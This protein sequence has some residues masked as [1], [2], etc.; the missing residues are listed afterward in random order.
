MLQ[1]DQNQPVSSENYCCANDCQSAASSGNPLSPYR[2][3]EPR[4]LLPSRNISGSDL[5][6]LTICELMPSATLWILFGQLP[7]PRSGTYLTDEFET[8]DGVGVTDAEP[9]LRPGSPG[10]TRQ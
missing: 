6:S 1:A 8:Q 2:S 3:R 5:T 4:S 9:G 7:L 10:K